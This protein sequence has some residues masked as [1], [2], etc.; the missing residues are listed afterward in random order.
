MSSARGV[1]AGNRQKLTMFSNGVTIKVKHGTGLVNAGGVAEGVVSE[2][3]GR[4]SAAS[5][6]L[7]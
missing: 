4:A 5:H 1:K 2:L 7:Q 6:R 3:P